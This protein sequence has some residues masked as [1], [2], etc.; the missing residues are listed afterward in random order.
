MPYSHKFF[1]IHAQSSV[2]IDRALEHFVRRCNHYQNRISSDSVFVFAT[3]QDLRTHLVY[4]VFSDAFCIA[5]GIIGDR[6]RIMRDSTESKV[7]YSNNIIKS[8]KSRK[9]G[10]YAA[11]NSNSV[12][13]N[14]IDELNRVGKL[15]N[16]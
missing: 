9:F 16:L 14:I 2:K 12:R 5:H 6:Y 15:D 10:V 13:P 11:P 7:I 1:F 8:D 4:Q 3:L